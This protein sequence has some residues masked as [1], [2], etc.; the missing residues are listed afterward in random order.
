MM[1]AR[2]QQ[3]AVA[4]ALTGENCL[5]FA[6]RRPTGCWATADPN[7]MTVLLAM[8]RRWSASPPSRLATGADRSHRQRWCLVRV[9]YRHRR[10]PDLTDPRTLRNPSWV[11]VNTGLEGQILRPSR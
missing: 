1:M 10:W 2:G 11:A 7:Q 6:T 3:L 8:L 4:A 9:R 5:H